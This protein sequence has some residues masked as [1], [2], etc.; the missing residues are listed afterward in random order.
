[1]VG[2]AGQN[3]QLP[4]AF[5]VEHNDEAMV[6]FA[7]GAIKFFRRESKVD[8]GEMTCFEHT[9]KSGR[10]LLHFYVSDENPYAPEIKA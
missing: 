1:V 7:N 8:A 6:E 2:L 10:A 3:R 5:P 4:A 9:V